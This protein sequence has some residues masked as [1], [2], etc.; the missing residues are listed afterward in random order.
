[1][2][3]YLTLFVAG[4]LTIFLP[5]ILPLV[6]VVVGVSI[7]GR[8]PFRP[9]LTVLGMVVS[10]VLFTFILL[11]VLN[12]FVEL[13]DYMRI[14]TYYI[15]LLF[16]VAF[17]SE[18]RIVRLIGAV[19]GGFF[20]IDKGTVSVVLAIVA[21]ILVMEAAGKIASR[22]QQFGVNAQTAARGEFGSDS[23]ITAFLIGLTLGLVWVPCAGPALGFALALVREQPGTMALSALLAYALGTAVPLILVGY[24]G[25]YAVHSVRSLSRYT[26]FV[27]KI[28]GTLLILTAVGLHLNLFQSL[29]VWIEDHMLLGNFASQ[30]EERLFNPSSSSG[31]SVSSASSMDLP[32][33]P[34]ITRAP[35]FVGLG[36][37]HNTGAF[38]LA[39]QKGKVVLVD[40]WTYSCINCIRTLPYI[41]G[42]WEKYK[43]T[44]KFVLIGVHT[45]EFTFEKSEKNV[46]MAIKQHKLTYPVAQD[47]DFGT[48]GAFANRYWP[49]KYLIDANG[50]I[51]YTHFGEGNYEETDRAIA[52][53]L[54]EAGI[55]VSAMNNMADDPE[56]SAYRS[57]TPETYL[58]SRSWP[59]FG[60]QQG[61]PTV[62]AVAYAK[63]SS[64]ALGKYYLSGTWKLVDDESQEL[65]SD[66]G[67]ILMKFTAGEIN[68]VLGLADGAEPVT[69]EVMLDGTSVKT[70][71]VAAHDLY[72]LYKGEYGEHEIVLK[73]K[74]KGVQAFAFTFGQ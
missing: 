68:L 40:F 45:P 50:Y 52:S 46:A 15:L 63:P 35:E 71:T 16:G 20:F 26:G 58:S 24:G 32:Q 72:E 10:F 31:S 43:D 8:S 34:T 74:G 56:G 66:E 65:Q 67:E 25:Q 51:R 47:N 2:I 60:N 1:M 69:V 44:D 27:K 73:F 53:L 33:L 28:A 36:P 37:W 18:W 70:F 61:E 9:L 54:K 62:A 59:A 21:G 14:A 13:S 12:S 57:L 42:Y 38:T 23:P 22:I 39:S 17:L 19:A 64:I 48:W 41:E 30:I 4:L 5:C 55:D 7:A 49:A 29:Q 3:I 6:P 11:T